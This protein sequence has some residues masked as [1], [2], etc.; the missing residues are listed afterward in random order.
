[1]FSRSPLLQL[2]ISLLKACVGQAMLVEIKSGETYNG[3][4]VSIDGFMNLCLSD[5]ILTSPKGDTF[6]KMNEVYIRGNAVKY[7]R[8]PDDV[9]EKVP[10]TEEF[11]SSRGRYVA[12]CS[13]LVR[14]FIS[15]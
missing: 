2:P 10:E 15:V 12:L 11:S 13:L 4:L 7:L 9:L 5:V 6:W 1:M 8:I 14:L 3:T